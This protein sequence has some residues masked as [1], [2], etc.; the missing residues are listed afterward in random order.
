MNKN[1]KSWLSSIAIVI[2]LILAFPFWFRVGKEMVYDKEGI[3]IYASTEIN[4]SEVE[5][6]AEGALSLLKKREINLHGST[7]IVFYDTRNEFRWRNFF[8]SSDALAMNWWPFP[9]I[10]FAPVDM[11]ED[12]QFARKEIL[13]QRSVSSVIA[14]ELTHTYQAE[15]L[16]I[17]GYKIQTMF[18]K[19]K[20][21]GMAE[22]VS[23]SSSVPTELGLELFMKNAD[24]DEV[25]ALGI[26]GEYF[27]FKSHLKAD[28]L[29]NVKKMSEADFWNT[30]IDEEKLEAEIRE[31]ILQELYQPNY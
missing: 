11:A 25:E 3:R 29:L 1:I 9:C 12:K 23:E 22:V 19:W 16:N 26:R 10:T 7:N 31:A 20:T 17:F 30:D 6:V 4:S 15:Q 21:E 27:Y 24:T 8:I 5:R 14:H 13:H 28:Y 2:A 18:H